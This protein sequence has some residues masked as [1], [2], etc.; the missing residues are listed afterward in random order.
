MSQNRVPGRIKIKALIILVAVFAVVAAG[1]V[2]VWQ[3]RKR[4]MADEARAA[5]LA[6]L[7]A[8]NVQEACLQLKRYLI[9]R[10]DDVEILE[11]YASARL[12]VRPRTQ[13]HLG[14]AIAA[15]RRLLRHR[16]HDAEICSRLAQLYLLRGDLKNLEWVCRHRL[17]GD[18]ADLDAR[19]N[20]A[21][22][23][24]GQD[25]ADEAAKLLEPLIEAHPHAVEA[26]ALYA[27]ALLRTDPSEKAVESVRNW[28]DLCVERNPGSVLAH[29]QRARFHRDSLSGRKAA[30]IA[31]AL[32][33]LETAE[34]LHTDQAHVVLDLANEWAAAGEPDRSAK[35]LARVRDPEPD[36]LVQQGLDPDK[37][38]LEWHLINA[39][40]A[41][42]RGSRSQMGQAADDAL[43]VLTG[44]YR[45]AY[46]ETAMDLYLHAGQLEKA[47]QVLADFR[48]VITL[49]AQ[50]LTGSD[51]I[52]AMF[53]ARIA[54]ARGRPYEAID[55]LEP[56]VARSPES[57]AVWRLLGQSH[58]LTGQSR[59]AIR[60]LERCVVLRPD[61]ESA[62]IE[63]VKQYLRQ[64]R[65]AD[66][67]RH[68]RNL[69]GDDL[70][71]NL[72]R[73]ESALRGAIQEG[74]RGETIEH[75]R[76]ELTELRDL[77]PDSS[78]I[79]LLLATVAE[80]E[81]RPDDAIS[82]L[83]NAVAECSDRLEPAIQLA[84]LNRRLGRIDA[85]I[86]VCRA[87]IERHRETAQPWILC[88][89]LLLMTG[90][91]QEARSTLTE[92]RQ[93]VHGQ[94]QVHDVEMAQALLHLRLDER[95]Q[96][97]A[98]LKQ[99][100][101]AKPGDVRARVAL[102]ELPEICRNPAEAQPLVE[103]IR[104]IE[105]AGSGVQ[106]RLHQARVWLA[107]EDRR[108]RRQE[109]VDLLTHCIEADPE[110]NRPVLILGGMYERLGDL[111]RAEQVYR[112]LLK[113]Q[114]D[115]IAVVDR[116]LRLLEQNNRVTEAKEILDRLPAELPGLTDHRIEIA[117]A[118]GEFDTAIRELQ[119]LV[120]SDPRNAE[121][122]ILLARLV[123]GEQRDAREA[124]RLLD[125]AAEVDPDALAVDAVRASILLAE[126]NDEQARNVLDERVAQRGDS[127]ALLLRAQFHVSQGRI[128]LA[129][130]DYRRLTTL[131]DAAAGYEVL[132]RFLVSRHRTDEAI[133]A[134][135]QAL[136][137]DP[138]R[139]S[140]RQWLMRLLLDDEKEERR[141]RGRDL[142]E[143]LLRDD[144]DN[145]DLL[146]VRGQLLMREQT[147]DATR[148]AERLLS[149]AVELDP[150]AV[151]AHIALIRIQADDGNLDAAANLADG[152]L[153]FNP[154]HP[155]LLLVQAEL[156]RARGHLA[157]AREL[158]EGV[159]QRHPDRVEAHALLADI[160]F[161]SDDLDAALAAITEAVDRA[162]DDPILQLKR[163]AVLEARGEM[164]PAVDALTE[165]VQSDAGANSTDAVLTLADLCCRQGDDDAYEQWLQRAEQLAPGAP[166]IAQR[167]L[168][169]LASQERF[170]EI[171]PLLAQW[172]AEKPD[173]LTTIVL[174]AGL[175]VQ[176]EVPELQRQ[177]QAF[178]EQVVQSDP[179]HAPGYLGLA[180]AAYAL[181]DPEAACD[182]YRRVLILDP[183]H[184]R[185]LN[186][187]AWILAVDRGDPEK[188]IILADWGA[189]LY[190]DDPHVR[191]TRGVIMTKLGRLPE[192][193][194]E[195][196]I[197]AELAEARGIH[198]THARALM[199]LAEALEFDGRTDA[200]LEKFE[201]ARRIDRDH[202]VLDAEE[203]SK[204]ERRL[205]SP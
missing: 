107:D 25:H 30:D 72:L 39:S 189:Q 70:E 130:R 71:S 190:Q 167:R 86:D 188:A 197:A 75:L 57:F 191:D 16:P 85:A 166:E 168:R 9:Q 36:T 32:A 186:D 2:A 5:G 145:A 153:G 101:A 61:D 49:A 172:R 22:S 178:L 58:V 47:D 110:W 96:A 165:Y 120:E 102:L 51:H 74:A 65:W 147:P 160:A 173:E 158:A 200:A 144:P 170:D 104:S 82:E 177:A 193:A 11:R 62:R 155:D 38:L 119:T 68:A 46:L 151:A 88:A 103:Q 21:R 204:I 163:A 20:L 161:H 67:M 17:E 118:T 53:A 8:G 115:A 194:R 132:G 81:N 1:A 142:L 55:A 41:R 15:Y 73:I 179:E 76:T 34:T 106:W 152:A 156:E 99:I 89:Q 201:A 196:E 3:L 78:A 79:R 112:R 29:T 150:Q 45:S 181:G 128:E 134:W 175:L 116:L 93:A 180:Q 126:G 176:S 162:P 28:L 97:V 27:N 63:L 199:H 66:A 184:N 136:D 195:L 137:I 37:F 202:G 109:V 44:G 56:V 143:D 121:A 114:P 205:D 169:C 122:R 48:E 117:T 24:L 108:A 139:A 100:A 171:T 129:E 7:N 148:E 140:T 4:M 182:A 80:Y 69:G 203:R 60:C 105:G 94:Q 42:Q 131:D 90:R 33:D 64:R 123:Y 43:A 84:Q 111:N 164:Q 138:N 35:A 19:I 183:D 192:A 87:A 14:Y 83:E 149:R 133:A 77:N 92:A 6:A 187:L 154:G 10:P 146:T 40:I 52:P 185:A 91:S 159:I 12:S 95:P 98:K 174:G 50:G 59:R 54:C 125:E 18:P 198:A 23:L 113:V 31:Q 26:Y 157:R 13:E 141:S 127:A 135:E 124:F